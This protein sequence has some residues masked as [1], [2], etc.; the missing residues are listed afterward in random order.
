VVVG[1]A[2]ATAGFDVAVRPSGKSWSLPNTADGASELV[3]SVRGVAPSLVLL[4]QASG[5]VP[6]TTAAVLEAALP[7][8][9][10][11]TGWERPSGY[12]RGVPPDPTAFGAARLAELGEA[13]ALVAG[14]PSDRDL[15][16][17][18]ALFG[19]RREVASMLTA[20][21]SRADSASAAVRQSVNSHV[22]WLQRTWGELDGGLAKALRASGSWISRA[23]LLGAAGGQGPAGPARRAERP[24][25]ANP[26]GPASAAK[27][28][29]TTETPDGKTYVMT[30][31]VRDQILQHARLCAPFLACGVLALRDEKIV[32]AYETDNTA[33]DRTRSFSFGEKGYR[34]VMAVERK[35]LM[36]GLYYSDRTSMISEAT[37]RG[38]ASTWPGCLCVVL[39]MGP[40][41]TVRGF[42]VD[43][44]QQA[45]EVELIV[46]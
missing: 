24:G 8:V 21:R 41:E 14:R 13:S 22:A 30:A 29:A 38:L 40:I 6:Q 9:V 31:A 27:A 26:V 15:L 19:R 46:E 12:G 11:G 17:L 4:E 42:L 44:K 18:R 10:V 45:R 25:A 34:A 37:I 23:E 39:G 3:T 16:E 1:V 36:V 20:E 33:R 7:V 5:Y 35:G 28:P 2:V 43:R 32:E